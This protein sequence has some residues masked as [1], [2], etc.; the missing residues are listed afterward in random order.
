MKHLLKYCCVLL[1]INPC[2]TMAFS[3]TNSDYNNTFKQNVR[4]VTSLYEPFV[5]LKDGKLVGFDIDLI[6]EICKQNNLTYSITI[7]SFQDIF[8][9]I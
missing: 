5:M 2:N 6:N 8:T 3:Y 4:I 9:Q 1:L 7:T